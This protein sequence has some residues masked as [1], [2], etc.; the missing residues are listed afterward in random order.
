MK[1]LISFILIYLVITSLFVGCS[2]NDEHPT[3]VT[4]SV[5]IVSATR[6]CSAY[7]NF[8]NPEI[9]ET[10][11]TAFMS[12][13]T[14]SHIICDGNPEVLESVTYKLPE[15][16]KN[17]STLIEKDAKNM[18]IAFLDNV[19]TT[20]AQ[21]PEVDILKALS[22]AV[23]SLSSAPSNSEKI[24]I[25]IDS[26]IQT[27]GM[28][29][30]SN[31]LLNAPAEKIADDLFDK[32]YIPDFNNTTIM[33]YQ[34][35]DVIA[36]QDE[37]TPSH[38]HKLKELWTSI[39]EKG[40]GKIIV[41]NSLPTKGIST[42]QLPFVTTVDMPADPVLEYT[43]NEPDFSQ[44][45]MLTESFIGF[46]PDSSELI[47][48]NETEKT[49]EPIATK[50]IENPDIILLIIGTTAGD[51]NDSFSQKLSK[52]R[53]DT[54][55]KILIKKGVKDENLKPIGLGSSDPWHISNVGLDGPLAEKNRKVVLIDAYS[56][57]G[58]ALI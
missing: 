43:G 37:L 34:L 7:P 25:V 41:S 28:I 2:S 20:I 45:L 12:S 31:N 51:E 55:K 19:S 53:A 23:R 16:Y 4:K 38:Q 6:S 50:L 46:L 40:N 13:G 56:S 33:W 8:N 24:I 48:Q 18:A 54:I 58:Q 22:N 32:G 27:T 47:N 57:M 15:Q 1:R 30:F 26:G 29:N 14:V 39:I 42:N 44:P 17:N 3:N 21:S 52:D 36:P 49:L 35:G 11:S 10:V 9:I 5:A